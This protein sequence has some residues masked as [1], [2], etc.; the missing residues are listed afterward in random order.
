MLTDS[1]DL[2]DRKI[3]PWKLYHLVFLYYEEFDPSNIALPMTKLT[4]FQMVGHPFMNQDMLERY[5]CKYQPQIAFP[6][7]ILDNFLHLLGS[8]NLH[9]L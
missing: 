2:L 6:L 8:S 5:C 3:L 1:V 4:A 7:Y 9:F